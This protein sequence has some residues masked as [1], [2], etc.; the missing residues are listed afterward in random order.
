M[1]SEQKAF[2]SALEKSVE[3]K[4]VLQDFNLDGLKA[5]AESLFAPVV[6]PES[7]GLPN[8]VINADG[9]PES[10]KSLLKSLE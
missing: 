10:V 5:K 3:A 7:N 9:V 1:T 4:K 8:G 2:V 6:L